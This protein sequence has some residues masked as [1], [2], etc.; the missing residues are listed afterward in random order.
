MTRRSA[1][2]VLSLTGLVAC[3]LGSLSGYSSGGPPTPADDDAGTPDG[4]PNDAGERDGDSATPNVDA[5]APFRCVD[6]PNAILC[7]DFDKDPFDLGFLRDGVG[8]TEATSTMFVSA[9]NALAASLPSRGDGTPHAILI[10][11]LDA[12]ASFSLS[13]DTRIVTTAPQYAVDLC[14]I[15]RLNPYWTVTVRLK[16]DL[17][18]RLELFEFGSVTDGV[19]TAVVA[20]TPLTRKLNPDAFSRVEMRVTVSGSASSAVV[21]IDGQIAGT[22]DLSAHHYT[23][24]PHATAGISSTDGSGGAITVITD[25][26]LLE[27]LEP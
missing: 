9:P 25:N 10:R 12:L 22:A 8:T 4:G 5:A 24:K 16:R 7:A 17:N 26:L 11:P 6:H 14:S 2:V 20:F 19:P 23:G 1:L 21:L 27:P 13:W 3:S 15:Y 18:E